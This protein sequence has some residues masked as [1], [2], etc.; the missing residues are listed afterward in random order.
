MA[1][2]LLVILSKSCIISLASCTDMEFGH[3]YCNF[4]YNMV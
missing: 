4:G 3:I 1:V 2:P